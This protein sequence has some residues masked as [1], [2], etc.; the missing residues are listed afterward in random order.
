MSVTLA[1]LISLISSFLPKL[2]CLS[3][4]KNRNY[5]ITFERK[6]CG[7]QENNKINYRGITMFPTLKKIY[8]M[9]LFD[10]GREYLFFELTIWIPGGIGSLEAPITIL[11]PI[12]HMLESG[13]KTFERRF[14]P[15]AAPQA[16][17]LLPQT[18]PWAGRPLP[19]Y[20]QEGFCR[21]TRKKVFDVQQTRRFLPRHRQECFCRTSGEM[22]L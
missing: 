16:R 4:F 12:N 13:N 5:F 18:A 22:V 14:V 15:Q 10:C 21:T 19:H 17:K 2:I 7:G 8:E 1:T 6:R 11:E 3:W 9:V 20:R